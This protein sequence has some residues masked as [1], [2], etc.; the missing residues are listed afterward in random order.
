MEQVSP[1]SPR[2]QDVDRNCLLLVNFQ[3]VKGPYCPIIQSFVRHNGFY[4]S[5]I[6][7]F[8]KFYLVRKC[9]SPSPFR[10]NRI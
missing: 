10:N 7:L 8:I 1:L 2:R 5:I 6:T 3:H 4:R 9:I